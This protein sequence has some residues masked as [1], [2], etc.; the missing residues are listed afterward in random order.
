MW[1]RGH[2]MEISAIK[3]V[4]K[5]ICFDPNFNFMFSVPHITKPHK[6]NTM[7]QYLSNGF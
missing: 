2:K 6:N 5:K 3:R 4:V 1:N 7:L